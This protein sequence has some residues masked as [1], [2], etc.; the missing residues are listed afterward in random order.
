MALINFILLVLTEKEIFVVGWTWLVIM[1]TFGT[2]GLSY[3]LAPILD[4][5][6]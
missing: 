6:K 5:K 1:G 2:M 4:R 3:V